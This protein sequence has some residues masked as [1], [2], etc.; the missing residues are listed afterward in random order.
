MILEIILDYE[1][2]QV[3]KDVETSKY[4][5]LDAVNNDSKLIPDKDFNCGRTYINDNPEYKLK[6]LKLIRR[7]SNNVD[8]FY[9]VSFPDAPADFDISGEEFNGTDYLY[10]EYGGATNIENS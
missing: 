7:V 2:F 9:D 8:G 1:D 6:E 4:Y 5:L 3:L 10:F